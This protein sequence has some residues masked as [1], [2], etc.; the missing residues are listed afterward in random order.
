MAHYEALASASE[1][2]R[3]PSRFKIEPYGILVGD[4]SVSE[5]H[6]AVAAPP[7]QCHFRGLDYFV[8]PIVLIL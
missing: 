3:P 6:P 8:I 2:V 1:E 5:C 4:T 7:I